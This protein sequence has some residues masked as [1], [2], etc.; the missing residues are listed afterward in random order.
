MIEGEAYLTLIA[1]KLNLVLVAT[2][3]TFLRCVNSSL[4]QSQSS[5]TVVPAG[6]NFEEQTKNNNF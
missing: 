1:H 4:G 2:G 3:L 6:S 5:F